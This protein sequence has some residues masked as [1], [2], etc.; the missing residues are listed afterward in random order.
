MITMNI[1]DITVVDMNDMAFETKQINLLGALEHVFFSL[2]TLG[3]V[4]LPTDLHVCVQ[5]G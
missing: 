5:R 2:K 3:G 1:R 4:V